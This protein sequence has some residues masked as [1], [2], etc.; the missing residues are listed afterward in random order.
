M[1]SIEHQQLVDGRRN[2]YD[3]V[4]SCVLLRRLYD[5]H[6]WNRRRRMDA[7]F[8]EKVN[9]ILVNKIYLYIEL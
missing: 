5:R 3:R 7:H 4:D 1:H 8:I 6:S 9:Y 2:L